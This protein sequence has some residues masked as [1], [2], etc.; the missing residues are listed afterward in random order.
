MIK[1]QAQTP[2]FK[3]FGGKLRSQI[4]CQ[5][6]SY[7]SDTFDETFTFNVP[8]PKADQCTFQESLKQFFSI[9]RLT[10]DNKYLCP[11]CKKKQDATKSLSVQLAPRILVV[12][13]KRFDMFGRKVTRRIKYPA[14]FNLKKHMAAAMDNPEDVQSLND[15]VYD[16]Y[17]VCVHS[18]FSTNSGHYYSY[19]KNNES[20]WF[21]CNDSFI[22]QA[23]EHEA[24]S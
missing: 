19:C 23:S 17:G 1:N 18:G 4:L 5:Q 3:I 22:S 11:V 6:C 7:K 8:L 20:K 14:T 10:K 13:V 21:E 2:L 15:E 16:L 12:T 9:D 24:L